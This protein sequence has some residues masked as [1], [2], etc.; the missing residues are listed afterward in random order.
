MHK[1]V[2]VMGIKCIAIKVDHDLRVHDFM[3]ECEWFTFNHNNSRYPVQLKCLFLPLCTYPYMGLFILNL[4]TTCW[5][6]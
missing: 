4:N 2:I 6:E 1:H 3:V 5:P